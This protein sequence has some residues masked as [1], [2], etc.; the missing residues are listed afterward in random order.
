MERTWASSV[1][2]GAPLRVRSDWIERG[3]QIAA[4]EDPDVGQALLENFAAERIEVLLETQIREVKGLSGQQVR[5]RIENS[6]G[7]QTIEGTDLL[8]ATG[9]TPDTLGIGLEKAGVEL[10]ARGYIK[11]NERLET[12]RAGRLGY[13]RLRWQPAVHTRR[14]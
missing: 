11:V 6:H 12:T 13:G 3:P 7:Q 9:R 1:A 5:V 8:V 2:G 10:D 14:V 4:A